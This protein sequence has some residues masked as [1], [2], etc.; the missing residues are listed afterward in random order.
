MFFPVYKTSTT[1]PSGFPSGHMA[2]ELPRDNM[3]SP[4]CSLSRTMQVVN[5]VSVTSYCLAQPAD[6]LTYVDLTTFVTSKIAFK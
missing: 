5:E 4:F 1:L 3:V 2:F 6:V